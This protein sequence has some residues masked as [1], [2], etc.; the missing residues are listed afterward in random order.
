[1]SKNRMATN[2]SAI[3][4]RKLAAAR[5][6]ALPLFAA[7]AVLLLVAAAARCAADPSLPAAGRAPSRVLLV[8]SYHPGYAWSDRIKQGIQEVFR[9]SGREIDLHFEYLDT[10]RHDPEALFPHLELLLARKYAEMPPDLVM[11]SDDNAL[12]FIMDRRDLFPGVPVVFCG[13]NDQELRLARGGGNITGVIETPDIRG[14]LLLALRLHPDTGTVYVVYDGVTSSR[15]V[16]R[17]LRE[18][19]PEFESRVRFEFLAGLTA[20]QLGDAVAALPPGGIV[21]LVSFFRDGDGAYVSE[22]RCRELMARAAVPV[23][24]SWDFYV[25]GGV[26]GGVTVSGYEQG[27]VAA[28]LGLRVLGGEPA[29]SIPMVMHSPNV[30]MFNY[31]QLAHHELAERVLPAGSVVL[32]RPRSVFTEY[33]ALVLGGVSVLAILVVIILDLAL[34]IVRRRRA[35][36]AL[37]A[38]EQRFR[39]LAEMLP[40]TIFEVD[41][42]GRITFVN[43][44]TFAKFG[45]SPQELEKGLHA[46]DMLVPEDRERAWENMSL[47]MRGESPGDQRSREYTALCRDGT[48][49]P[50]LIRSGPIMRGGE[51]VGL[52]GFLI[53]ITERKRQEERLRMSERKYRHLVEHAPAGIYEFDMRTLR[54]TGVNDVM[55]R[56]TGY[57]EEEF[58]ALDPLD[59]LT[60]DSKDDLRRLIREV[61]EGRHTVN[62]V[63]YGI[64]GKNGREFRVLVNSTFFFEDGE[65]VRAMGVAHDVTELRRAEE[66]AGRLEASLLQARKMESIGTLAGGVAHEFNN[67]LMAV[68]GRVSLM[69]MDIDAPHPFHEHL[70]GI[71]ESVRSAAVLTGQLLGFAREGRYEPLPTD[72]N[73]LAVRVTRMYARTRKDVRLHRRLREGLWAVEADRSQM[74]QVLMNL[75]INAG[76]SMPGGG[77]IRVETGNLT[78]DRVEAAGCRLEP[79]RYVLVSVADT[80]CGMDEET[81]ER[82]FEPFF[83]PGERTEGSGLGLASAYGIVRNHGGCIE[84]HSEPGRGTLFRVLLPAVEAL[85]QPR[86]EREE[87]IHTGCGEV[88]L[89]DDEEIIRTLGGRMLEKLGYRVVAAAGGREAVDILAERGRELTLVILDLVM[90]GMNGVQ[91]FARLRELRH[92]LPVLLTSGYDLEDRAEELLD[93]GAVGFIKKPFTLQQLSAGL[94]Q[95]LGTACGDTVG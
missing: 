94:R 57:T 58:L 74:E 30:P 16:V 83:T 93:L 88:L 37:R 18:M 29:G 46:L 87:P 81:R 28:G 75:L 38:S 10:K 7:A 79:G 66:E 63:E 8:N 51:C 47:I 73:V 49:F 91:T 12:Q 17:Q 68:Q 24:T 2:R 76:Q 36:R 44:S 53:D 23:Y 71:E 86:Q 26:L 6:A 70:K 62:P 92:G 3:E 34:N 27:R 48:T 45:Y 20:A 55:C 15:A 39:E 19:T 4:D 1:M 59:L 5:A 43:L 69:L 33:R 72:M 22:Q 13:I 95:V 61:L 67:L 54:F 14:T 40:E 82:I 41:H 42:T 25:G 80:G 78:L 90:P 50:V 65:P 77:E 60:D 56:Y 84:V 9:S 35:E 31:P 32:G 52:R 64:R 89:V 85:V 11:V 21:Y